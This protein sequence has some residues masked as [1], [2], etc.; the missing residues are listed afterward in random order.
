VRAA[1]DCL[2][3]AVS[4]HAPSRGYYWLLANCEGPEGDGQREC[5]LRLKALETPVHHAAEILYINRDREWGG[6]SVADENKYTAYTL[7]ES[8]RDHRDMLAFDP[9]YYS[10][11]FFMAQRLANAGRDE[12]ALVAWYGC[13]AIS[14]NDLGARSNRARHLA[15][16]GY[17]DEALDDLEIVADADPELGFGL[18]TDLFNIQA[19]RLATS[20][21]KTLRDGPRAVEL[22]E[23]ACQRT[24][25]SDAASLD[26]LS[27]AYAETGDFEAAIR[28]SERALSFN[29]LQFAREIELHLTSFRRNEPWRED[30]PTPP[31]QARSRLASVIRARMDGLRGRYLI[32]NGRRTEG[33]DALEAS[34]RSAV[35]E[36]ALNIYDSEMRGSD[37]TDE[38][39]AFYRELVEAHPQSAILHFKLAISLRKAGALDEAVVAEHEAGR[40]LPERF[41]AEKIATWYAIEGLFVEAEATFE[42]VL[43]SNP[44]DDASAM[45]LALI[46]LL[47]NDRAGYEDAC[48]AMLGRSAQI[49]QTKDGV[50]ARRTV[51]ACCVSSPPVGDVAELVRLADLAVEEC[52]RSGPYLMAQVCR[53]RGLVAY[54]AGDWQGALTWSMKSIELEQKPTYQAQ[55]LVVAAMA[56]HQLGKRDEALD[57]YRRAVEMAGRG[58][59]TFQGDSYPRLVDWVDWVPYEWPRREAAQLLG[60]DAEGRDAD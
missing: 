4:F 51:W 2:E 15:K 16:L 57:H 44:D 32:E 40:L 17:Y 38:R 50:E 13:L 23:K 25:Y 5:E 22:A 48:R 29:P 58:F 11:M 3:T 43:L 37:D 12:E 28:W 49:A 20:R 7:D 56:L 27:A 33:I 55:N 39:L 24:D 30:A 19:W 52:S 59:P 36:V 10:G 46:R 26:T 35:T 53:E 21:D 60:L 14:P 9:Q 8:Y 31:A 1:R 47:L 34:L 6:G 18:Q 41:S 45:R 42:R 54:R